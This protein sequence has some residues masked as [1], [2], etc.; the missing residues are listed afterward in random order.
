[1]SRGSRCAQS[2]GEPP[3]GSAGGGTPGALQIRVAQA[4]I[5]ERTFV[6]LDCCNSGQCFAFHRGDTVTNTEPTK[7]RPHPQDARTPRHRHLGA[8]L[9]IISAAQLMVMLDV[10][11]VNVALPSIQKA[12]WFSSTANLAWV[13]T[14]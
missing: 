10:T 13:I 12:L 1:M 4:K 6:L 5:G 8:T 3:P 7:R 11:I 14:A 2:N 9:A